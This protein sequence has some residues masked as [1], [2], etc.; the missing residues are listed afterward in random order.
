MLR[1]DQPTHREEEIAELMGALAF[2]FLVLLENLRP[3]S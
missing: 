2:A 3:R 1:W